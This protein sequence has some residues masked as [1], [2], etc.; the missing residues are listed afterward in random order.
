MRGK[1]KKMYEDVKLR[2]G[3]F[4]LKGELARKRGINTVRAF[5]QSGVKVRKPQTKE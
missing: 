4:Y 5:K 2:I 1:K 3:P